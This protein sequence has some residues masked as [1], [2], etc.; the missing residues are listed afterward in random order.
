[1]LQSPIIPRAES[2]RD[3]WKVTIDDN[4]LKN[5]RDAGGARSGVI[6]IAKREETKETVS[7]MT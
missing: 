7:L 4:G 5:Q 2:A 1:M 3:D 6:E